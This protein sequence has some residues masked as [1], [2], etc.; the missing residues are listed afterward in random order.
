MNRIVVVGGG[1]IGSVLAACLARAGQPVVLVARPAQAREA[2]KGM[3]VAEPDGTWSVPIPS[4]DHP[5]QLGLTSDDVVVL[6]VKSYDTQSALDDLREAASGQLPAVVSTQNGVDNEVAISGS[7]FPTYAAMIRIAG[8]LL[9]PGL[10]LAKPPRHMVLGVYPGGVDDVCRQLASS[11]IAGGVGTDLSAAAMRDKWAKLVTNT[12]NAIHALT[13]IPVAHRSRDGVLEAMIEAVR[14]EAN[15]VLDRAGI[16]HGF[17]FSSAPVPPTPSTD[18]SIP[19]EPLDPPPDFNEAFYGSMWDDLDRRRGRTEVGHLNGRIV[20]VA[21]EI[22][23]RAP[24]NSRLVELC[25]AAV[26]GAGQPRAFT[27]AEL[28]ATLDTAAA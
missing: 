28:A 15:E 8:R 3:V 10:V 26:V 21:N 17:T 19:A 14:A 6:A 23:I 13:G 22:G 2:A 5:G 16:E 11:F 24:R 9:R 1:G 4:V 25:E 7:G 18:L 12:G 20:V 27:V